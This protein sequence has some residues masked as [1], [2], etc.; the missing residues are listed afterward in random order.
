MLRKILMMS[1]AGLLVMSLAAGQGQTPPA[2]KPQPMGPSPVNQ[3]AQEM[4]ARLGNEM[5]VKTIIGQPVK[6]GAVTIIPIMMIDVSFG[7]GQAGAP[8]LAA[9][10]ATGYYMSGEARPLGFVAVTKKGT[11][12]ISVGLTPHK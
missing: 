2:P 8:Q 12:F 10:G 5:N 3:L 1:A 9:A 11:R 7:G 6:A 4:A